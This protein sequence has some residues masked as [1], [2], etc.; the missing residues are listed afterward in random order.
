[1]IVDCHTHITTSVADEAGASEYLQA[2]GTVDV[3]IVLAEAKGESEEVNKELSEYVGKY[4]E[5]LIGFAV[6][7][8]IN[9]KIGTKT[10]SSIPEKLGLKGAVL[11]CASCDFHPVHSRAMR[12]YEAAEEIGLPVFFHNEDALMDEAVLN[13]AQPFLLDE[14]ARTF[15]ELKI[16]IGT[17]GVP[18]VDQTLAVIGKHKNVYA[19]LTIQPKKVWQVYNM[20]VSAHEN[21]VM[22]KLLFGSGF[23]Y[24][25]AGECIET[26][27]GFN[28]LLG[29]TNLPTVRRG[30][31]RNIIERDTL[32]LLGIEQ[33]SN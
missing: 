25:N 19:D 4:K 24:G 3:S 18:F 13:H 11:Y 33:F 31:I 12:F 9:D 6:V 20:V 29:D 26:L 10:I 14:V 5:K 27:L 1:M 8:P 22:D 32:E 16:I 21:G 28:K 2:A 17:M 7:D 15:P 30:D 23:P